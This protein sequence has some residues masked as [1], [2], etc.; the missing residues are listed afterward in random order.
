[1]S[2]VI[3]F[4][5]I[6][7]KEQE[8][9]EE[10]EDQVGTGNEGVRPGTGQI[11]AN[12]QQQ[13][14]ND[15]QLLDA[16]SRTVVDVVS[17][18]S[19][20]VV[21]VQVRQGGKGVGVANKGASSEQTE[22][23]GSGV[24]LS[25]DGIILTNQHVIDEATDIKIRGFEGQDYSARVIGQD[26]DTDLAVLHAQTDATL[27]Y[28]PL[29]DSTKLR[30]GQ[31]VVAI[32]NPLGFES[33]VTTGVISAVGRSLRAR[34]GRLIDDVLQTDAAIN[35]GNSGGPLIS[36]CGEVIGINT[37]IIARAYGIGFSVASN[38]ARST[39]TQIL[40]H[41][42]VRRG[43]IGI[44]GQ[45]L[46]LPPQMMNELGLGEPVAVGVIDIQPQSPAVNAG[47]KQGDILVKIGGQEVSGVDGLLKILDSDSIGHSCELTFYR[48]NKLYRTQ[49]TPVDRP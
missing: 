6:F 37:A 19:P 12:P 47:L 16:Y 34:N 48:D 36:S 13:V 20:A 25:P 11:I 28:A 30:A 44:A 41:G 7:G 33:S 29:G 22:G 32:G 2:R 1:M 4:P 46:I 38:T 10:P 23:G 26:P 8:E 18:V 35:P 31:L 45:T 21:H 42:R 27:A 39:L 9:Q 5:Q 14:A 3:G 43:F 49:I 40:Q 24:I 15:D 17:K